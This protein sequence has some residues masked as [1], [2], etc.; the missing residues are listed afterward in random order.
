M[1]KQNSFAKAGGP[2]FKSRLILGESVGT[3]IPVFYFGERRVGVV[4]TIIENGMEQEL[5]FAGQIIPELPVGR[6]VTINHLFQVEIGISKRAVKRAISIMKK[7]WIE[8]R[9]IFFAID[10]AVAIPF[11]VEY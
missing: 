8:T 11:I 2:N 1:K 5:V 7:R 4:I 9:G 10:I 3:E 6:S